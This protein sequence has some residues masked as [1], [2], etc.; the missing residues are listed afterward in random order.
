MGNQLLDAQIIFQRTDFNQAGSVKSRPARIRSPSNPSKQ[1]EQVSQSQRLAFDFLFPVRARTRQDH[2]LNSKKGYP[3][4]ASYCTL[5]EWST[6][7]PDRP[8]QL[9]AIRLTWLSGQKPARL[10]HPVR[11]MS[12]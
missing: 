6:R 4:I 8:R 10:H 7:R 1:T 12:G 9:N 11:S 3:R 5:A 2:Q